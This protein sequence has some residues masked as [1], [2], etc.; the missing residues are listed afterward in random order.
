[1]IFNYIDDLFFISEMTDFYKTITL[2]NSKNNSSEK[3]KK[4]ISL[5]KIK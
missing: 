2:K 5:A 4:S 1:M 3:P